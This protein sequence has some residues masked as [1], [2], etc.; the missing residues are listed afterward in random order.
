MSLIYSSKLIS[1]NVFPLS[2]KAIYRQLRLSK[3]TFFD[4]DVFQGSMLSLCSMTK[5]I[6]FLQVIASCSDSDPVQLK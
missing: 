1:T 5:V 6:F 2:L 4:S 3:N